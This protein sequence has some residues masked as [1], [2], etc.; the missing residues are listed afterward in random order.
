[1]QHYRDSFIVDA[2][3]GEVFRF[4]TDLHNLARMVPPHI[5]MRVL[6]AETPLKRGSTIRFGL[7][8][9]GV[10]IEVRWVSRVVEFRENEAFADKQVRG[11]FEFWRHRHE[12]RALEDG[13]T[14]VCDTIE[15]GAPLGFL[16]PV[17]EGLLLGQG[18]QS[19]FDHRRRIVREAFPSRQAE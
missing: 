11:P 17:L 5:G 3:V 13:R 12:F 4:Y 1:M 6:K 2:P 8:P 16:A 15:A 9:R 10:P 7:R 19:L 14:E 18:I